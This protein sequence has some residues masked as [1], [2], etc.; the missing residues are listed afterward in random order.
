MH[1]GKRMAIDQYDGE[2][3]INRFNSMC[4]AAS[5]LGISQQMISKC[6][7]G[8]V[9]TYKGFRWIKVIEHPSPNEFWIDHP[10]LNSVKCS[11]IGRI[12]NRGVISVG[13][14]RD[15][16]LRVGIQNKIYS[17][18]RLICET[19]HENTYDYSQ[20]NHINHDRSDNRI[21]NLEWCTPKQ[22]SNRRR[23]SKTYLD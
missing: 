8:F 3:H 13:H 4:E 10:V 15:G 6:A 9:A 7:R 2:V 5:E 16:Y 23:I 1:G 12:M 21:S 20:V 22:N 11:N 14:F 17:A 18:H 19:F